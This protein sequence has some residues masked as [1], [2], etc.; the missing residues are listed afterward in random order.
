MPMQRVRRANRISRAEFHLRL[1]RWLG[2]EGNEQRID[3]QPPGTDDGHCHWVY[4][5]DG[6]SI[7][8]LNADS[9][10]EGVAEYLALVLQHGNDLAWS[11][12]LNRRKTQENLVGFGP[13]ME[14]LTGIYLYYE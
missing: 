11:P 12:I 10:R 9:T 13:D 7:C 4:V 8:Y 1:L 14:P 2:E 6:E 3:G 5:S